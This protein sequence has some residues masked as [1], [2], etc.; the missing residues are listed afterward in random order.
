MKK[1]THLVVF[2]VLSGIAMLGRLW[3]V[4]SGGRIDR[5]VLLKVAKDQGMPSQEEYANFLEGQ[6]QLQSNTVNKVLAVLLLVAFIAFLV[7]LIQKK[8]E[9]ASFVYIGYLFGTLIQRTYDFVVLKGISG[10][11]NSPELRQV[12]DGSV[13]MVFV[14]GIV[15]FLIYFGL[16]TFFHLR[17]P[18]NSELVEDTGI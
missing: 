2:A 1:W 15:L 9:L 6:L 18:K 11:V 8:Y 16:A 3:G 10:Q 7:F 17:K 4:F 12:T 13:L 5:D 14:F